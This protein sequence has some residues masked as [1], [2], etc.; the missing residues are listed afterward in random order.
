M[1]K[2]NKFNNFILSILSIGLITT[3]TACS[4][5]GNSNIPKITC[6]KAIKVVDK[7]SDQCYVKIDGKSE[8]RNP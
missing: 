8:N 2:L 1:K 4:R 5:G 7:N 6:S 3:L